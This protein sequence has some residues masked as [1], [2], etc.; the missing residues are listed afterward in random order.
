MIELLHLAGVIGLLVAAFWLMDQWDN[1][2]VE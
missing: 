1:D 2:D